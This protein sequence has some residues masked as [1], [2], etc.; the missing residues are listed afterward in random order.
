MDEVLSVMKRARPFSY[1]QAGVLKT[2]YYDPDRMIFIAERGD[3]VTTV[4]SN[5]RPG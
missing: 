5:V 1:R 3:S 2:G 4:I